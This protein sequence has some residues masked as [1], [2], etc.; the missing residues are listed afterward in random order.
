M[1]LKTESWNS[2][3]IQ[4]GKRIK[5]KRK[6]RPKDSGG[7]E[8]RT[9]LIYI[10]ADSEVKFSSFTLGKSERPCFSIPHLCIIQYDN[11]LA[12]D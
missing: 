10:L 1:L 3:E 4:N 11:S 9:E 12:N 6:F 2:V 8:A 7:S 5:S